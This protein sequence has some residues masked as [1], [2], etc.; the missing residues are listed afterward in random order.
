MAYSTLSDRTALNDW[1]NIPSIDQFASPIKPDLNI[2]KANGVTDSLD[3]YLHYFYPPTDNDLFT[4]NIQDPCAATSSP[5]YPSSVLSAVSPD[6]SLSTPLKPNGYPALPLIPIFTPDDKPD[7]PSSPES[8][9]NLSPLTFRPID[10][11]QSTPFGDIYQLSMPWISSDSYISPVVRASS[12]GTPSKDD[13]K[14]A[15]ERTNRRVSSARKKKNTP[16]LERLRATVPSPAS[17]SPDRP[18]AEVL[19]MRVDALPPL[20]S[21][22][23]T[24][25]PR[26]MDENATRYSEHIALQ[27]DGHDYADVVTPE[28]RTTDIMALSPLTPLTPGLPSVLPPR[29]PAKKGPGA[30]R[31]KR[32]LAYQDSFSPLPQL[33]KTR[34]G[35]RSSTLEMYSYKSSPDVLDTPTSSSVSA[36]S[37]PAS[38]LAFTVPIFTT[39]TFPASRP[40]EISPDYPLFYRRFPVSS[41]F[42]ATPSEYSIIASLGFVF[43]G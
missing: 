30:N 2:S 9:F 6:R 16:F 10:D 41:Y 22:I 32:K 4:R 25:I 11:L 29:I 14:E 35:L 3:L 28:R 7:A 15:P 18:L 36:P 40:I 24:S 26:N 8:H 19:R 13:S 23:K 21:P 43:I 5:S 39:R 17:S 42:Q 1:L 20:L 12:F 27:H 33:K 34:R 37:L 31:P 38:P